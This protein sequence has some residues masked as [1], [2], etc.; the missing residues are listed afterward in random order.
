MEELHDRIERVRHAEAFEASLRDDGIDP[1]EFENSW[2][3]YGSFENL[4]ATYRRA[5][6]A[7]EKEASVPA[8]S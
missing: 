8:Q 6:L 7:G 4:P 5:I 2:S 3:A 1:D